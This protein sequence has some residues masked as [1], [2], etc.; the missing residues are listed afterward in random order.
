MRDLH[1]LDKYR[2]S[3]F[4]RKFYGCNGDSG[5]GVFLVRIKGKRYLIIASNGGGWDHVSI[6]ANKENYMPTWDVLC[7]VKQ[8]FFEDEEEVV[9]FFPRKSEYVNIHEYCLHLWRKNTGGEIE[10][11]KTYMV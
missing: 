11:P 8:L 3:D 1:T 5:N 6:S 10:T 2:K 4:E 9:Q 7:A